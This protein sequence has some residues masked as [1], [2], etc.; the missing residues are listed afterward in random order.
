MLTIIVS[1][2]Y[3]MLDILIIDLWSQ[4]S[5]K[6]EPLSTKKQLMKSNEWALTSLL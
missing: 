5:S 4:C 6:E 2:V 3:F 1:L